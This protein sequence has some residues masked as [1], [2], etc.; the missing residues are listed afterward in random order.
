VR[1]DD[2]EPV[3]GEK[4]Q[5]SAGRPKSGRPKRVSSLLKLQNAFTPPPAGFSHCSF[6]ASEHMAVELHAYRSVPERMS[7]CVAPR[8]SEK[9]RAKKMDPKMKLKL[10]FGCNNRSVRRSPSHPL[11]PNL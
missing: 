2:D 9:R 4:R 10:S 11:R 3:G 7:R 6:R 8:V 1:P 5:R